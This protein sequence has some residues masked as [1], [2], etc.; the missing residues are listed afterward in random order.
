[1]NRAS[2]MILAVVLLLLGAQAVNAAELVAIEE[3]YSD[4]FRTV[5]LRGLSEG[6]TILVRANGAGP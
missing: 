6:D 1:M 4:G 5:A 3:G 2:A